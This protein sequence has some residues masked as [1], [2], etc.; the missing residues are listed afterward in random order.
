VLGSVHVTSQAVHAANTYRQGFRLGPD[1]PKRTFESRRI[2]SLAT[3]A[4]LN[5]TNTWPVCLYFPRIS[6][7][8]MSIYTRNTKYVKVPWRVVGSPP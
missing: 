1:L 7:I 5:V 3:E 4:L 8:Y 2:T 6:V